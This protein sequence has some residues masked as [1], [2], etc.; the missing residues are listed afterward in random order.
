[1]HVEVHVVRLEARGTQV[2]VNHRAGLVEAV[3]RPVNRLVVHLVHTHD[4]LPQAQGVR[5]QG[6]LSDLRLAHA[7][8]GEVCL[9]RGDDQD[10][11]VGLGHGSHDVLRKVVVPGRIDDGEATPP[12]RHAP[13]TT[14]HGATTVAL[15]LQLVQ[16]PGIASG[17]LA[18]VRGLAL[19]PLEVLLVDGTTICDEATRHRGLAASAWPDEHAVDVRQVG[20]IVEVAHSSSTASRARGL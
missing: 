1:V 17:L 3:L 18:P 10:S 7:T 15:A 5:H 20:S 2:P 13:Q 8:N 19:D 11:D 14:I 16:D 12:G 9:L 6:V 4:E